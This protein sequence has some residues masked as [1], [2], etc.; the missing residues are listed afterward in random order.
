MRRSSWQD[1]VL[2]TNCPIP[3]KWNFTYQFQVKDQ[4][5]SFFYSPSLNLQ[6]ASGGFGSFIIT[7]RN[8]ISIPFS[9]PD[10]DIVIII[11]DWYT[12][13]H[14]VSVSSIFSFLFQ[15]V[16]LVNLLV[17]ALIYFQIIGFEEGP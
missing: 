4:I 15:A 3:A 12:R 13:D 17:P 9:P 7:N 1:G 2:G 10:G 11:G 6:R 8:I 5:G 16:R 14:K